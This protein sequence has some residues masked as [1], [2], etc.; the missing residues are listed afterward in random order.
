LSLH[1]RDAG[2]ADYRNERKKFRSH[3]CEST[4]AI[5]L[6]STHFPY[7]QAES[8]LPSSDYGMASKPAWRALNVEGW[9]GFLQDCFSVRA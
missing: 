8:D 9:D 5:G 2:K 6:W 1:K 4:E 3:N 7:E